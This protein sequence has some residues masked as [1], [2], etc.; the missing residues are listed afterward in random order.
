MVHFPAKADTLQKELQLVLKAVRSV[1]D[2]TT[3]PVL[4]QGVLT[5]GNYVNSSS[6]SLGGAVG[7]TLESLAKLAHTRYRLKNA[8]GKQQ[9]DSNALAMIVQHLEKTRPNFA[10][11]L[12]IDLDGCHAAQHFDQASTAAA[13]QE[14]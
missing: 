1:L 4:L 2:S 6:K 3:I 14:L 10:Q 8:S 13:V 5:L 7:V 12:A 9:K 11:T